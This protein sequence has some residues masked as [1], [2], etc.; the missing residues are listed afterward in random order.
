M[1]PPQRPPPL[2]APAVGPAGRRRAGPSP[3]LTEHG[4][5]RYVAAGA[6]HG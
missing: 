6:P 4:A 1:P 3:G 2:P 5:R